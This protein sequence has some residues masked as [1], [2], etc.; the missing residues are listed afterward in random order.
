MMYENYHSI[1]NDE[2]REF[3]LGTDVRIDIEIYLKSEKG[4]FDKEYLIKSIIKS[5][6]KRMSQRLRGEE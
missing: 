1:N 5:Y 2:Y 3:L 4:E 6:E